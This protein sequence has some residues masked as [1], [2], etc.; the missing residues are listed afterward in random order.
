MNTPIDTA[1][2]YDDVKVILLDNMHQR[3]L[4]VPTDIY[5]KACLKND[6]LELHEYVNDYFEKCLAHRFDTFFITLD[7]RCISKKL[8]SSFCK[9]TFAVNKNSRKLI[10]ERAR[11]KLAERASEIKPEDIKNIEVS[12]LLKSRHSVP[13]LINYKE[14]A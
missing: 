14:S 4:D 8:P 2:S 11:E 3:K 5:E 13:M 1:T 10:E 12:T 6:T 9:V 7:K